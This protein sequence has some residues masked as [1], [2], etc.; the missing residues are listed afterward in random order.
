MREIERQAAEGWSPNRRVRPQAA[1]DYLS[2]EL[3]PN[4]PRHPAGQSDERGAESVETNRPRR[5][6]QERAPEY[7]DPT[8]GDKKRRATSSSGGDGRGY[9]RGHSP[10]DRGSHRDY[11]S[12]AA[13]ARSGSRYEDKRPRK[14]WRERDR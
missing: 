5:H 7:D 6:D 8:G 13:S 11:S 1:W 9:R 2:V 3:P 12:Y 10:A 4:R 14:D